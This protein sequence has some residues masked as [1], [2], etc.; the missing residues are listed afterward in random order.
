MIS[1]SYIS[2]GFLFSDHFLT[3]V[4]KD[5]RNIVQEVKVRVRISHSDTVAHYNG[6]VD[7]TNRV[8]L[9][10]RNPD[11]TSWSTAP[12]LLGKAYL[13]SMV[14]DYDYKD[15]DSRVDSYK[16]IVRNK[17]KNILAL[18]R[19]TEDKKTKIEEA[20]LKFTGFKDYS[21][22]YQNNLLGY[23]NSKGEFKPMFCRYIKTYV[24]VVGLQPDPEAIRVCKQWEDITKHCQKWLQKNYADWLVIEPPKQTKSVTQALANKPQKV[25][26]PV[27]TPLTYKSA[28]NSQS[29]SPPDPIDLLSEELSS[30]DFFDDVNDTEEIKRYIVWRRGQPEFRRKLLDAYGR[31]VI[32]GCTSKDALEAA[33]IRPYS[34]TKNNDPSNGLLL[35]AD[36]HTLFD[37][38]LI[39]I[40][41]EK[42]T[43]CIAQSLLEDYGQFNGKSLQLPDNDRLRDSLRTRYQEYKKRLDGYS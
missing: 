41:P 40:D 1:G 10:I 19:G 6:S 39:G 11:G 20:C 31:C 38:H 43:V 2:G 21:L 7:R 35:R 42:M 28:L 29:V 5:E 23:V 4:T 37:R 26:Q 24:P 12:L 16:T 22:R 14:E 36:I 25:I 30:T 3:Q 34:D 27:I 32:T 33:H 8:W 13:S 17:G 9:D 18:M 15:Y